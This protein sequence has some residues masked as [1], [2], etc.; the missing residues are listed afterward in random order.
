MHLQS[1]ENVSSFLE[2]YNRI[3][4]KHVNLQGLLLIFFPHNGFLVPIL[5]QPTQLLLLL[6]STESAS[7]VRTA[8]LLPSYKLKVTSPEEHFQGLYLAPEKEPTLT[9]TILKIPKALGICSNL[10]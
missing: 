4:S 10:K 9:Q 5:S 2:L 1:L 8:P 6:H 7:L 3:L